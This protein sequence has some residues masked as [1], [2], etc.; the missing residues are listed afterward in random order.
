MPVFH[1]VL[2]KLAD[3]TDVKAV[4]TLKEAGEALQKIPGVLSVAM[5]PNYTQ[6]GRGYNF[7]A[8][9]TFET[10]EDEAKYQVHPVHQK[11]VKEKIKPLLAA[12]EAPVLAVDFSNLIG[13]IS[14]V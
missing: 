12:D 8:C 14:K 13:P 1:I 10:K 5:G 11:T 4:A 7:A 6:R 2:F 3:P 9:M